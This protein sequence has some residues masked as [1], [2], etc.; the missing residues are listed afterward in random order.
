MKLINKQIPIL[1]SIKKLAHQENFNNLSFYQEGWTV[2]V[3]FAYHEF[4]QEEAEKF[5][6]ELSKYGGKI[7]LAKDSSLD[8]KNF[9]LMYPEYDGWKK[10]VKSVDPKNLYQSMLSKRLGLKEW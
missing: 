8:E 4:N 5:Y 10:I 1:C 3:D 9:R 7:Y 6:E 2:A